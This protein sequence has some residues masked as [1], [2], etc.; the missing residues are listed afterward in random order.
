MNVISYRRGLASANIL[1][2]LPSPSHACAVG[3]VPSAHTPP[4]LS[5]HMFFSSLEEWA[6]KNT[7]GSLSVMFSPP[8]Q[9]KVT[10]CTNLFAARKTIGVCS[11]PASLYMLINIRT[12][13]RGG[14]YKQGTKGGLFGYQ[15]IENSTLAACAM[16]PVELCSWE[17]PA[18]LRQAVL[19]WLKTG[20]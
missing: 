2:T 13:G 12:R 16:G 9:C 14:G 10:A 11:A 19:V 15:R 6:Y 20:R 5:P 3:T 8:L 4:S 1:C 17:Y 7:T 18:V